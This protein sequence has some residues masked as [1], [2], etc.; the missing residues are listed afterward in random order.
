MK[1]TGLSLI[2]LLAF[3]RLAFPAEKDEVFLGEI[4]DSQCAKMESHEMMKKKE[5][6][7]DAR[8]CTLDCVRMGGKY[9]LYDAATKT[10]HQLEDQEKLAEFAGQ[11]VKVTGT[12]DRLADVIHIIGIQAVPQTFGEKTPAAVGRLVSSERKIQATLGK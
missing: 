10:T 8:E 3:L 4:I 7:R 6:A 1:Q 2:L 5:G 12:R 11:R 9:V